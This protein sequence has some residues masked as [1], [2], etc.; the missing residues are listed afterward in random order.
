MLA[1]Y[2][3]IK[4]FEYKLKGRKFKLITDHTAL[5]VIRKKPSFDNNIINR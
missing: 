2:K 1:I 3:G 5:K 4:R